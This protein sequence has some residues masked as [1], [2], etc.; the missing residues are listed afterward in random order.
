MALATRPAPPDRGSATRHPLASALTVLGLVLGL[1]LGLVAAGCSTESDPV[2]PS[3]GAVTGSVS[4]E[5]AQALLD[6]RS[7]AVR[8]GDRAAFLATLDPTNP[9]LLKRQRR[10]FANL[11]RLPVQT[12]RYTVLKSE[13]PDG[14]RARSWGRFVSVPQVRVS[15]QLA[16][17]DQVP[18]T[19]ISGFAFTRIDGDP[20]ILSELTGAG[21]QFPGSS[22]APWDLVRV[23]VRTT[24]TT[25]ELY[26]DATWRKADEISATVRRGIADVQQGL[27]FDWDGRVVVYVFSEQKVLDS[28]EGVPGGNI[29]HLGAMTFPMYAVMG[30]PEVA[31]IRFTLLPSSIR[32]G[33]PFLDRITRH[34]LTHVAVGDRDDGVPIWFAEGIAEYMGARSIPDDERRI[35]TAAVNRARRGV[36]GLPTSASFNSDEQAW[37]YALSWMACDFIAS[38]QGEPRLWELMDALRDAGDGTSESEQDAVLQRVIGLDGE[39]LAREAAR[40]ILRIYG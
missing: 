14:L 39:Q 22:P 25:L 28:F 20:V 30:Q 24:A 18:V 21:L 8:S 38:T 6:A 9:E 15:T 36:D 27:P 10:Y 29:N 26:D 4:A 33:Q 1:L 13:W 2:L 11:Q 12:L 40:R 16:G 5:E 19:R 32:A 7:D 37:N 17:F 31:S 23:Q 35:A 34:E 3:A